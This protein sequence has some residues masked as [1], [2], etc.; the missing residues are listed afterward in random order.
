MG[1]V[2]GLAAAIFALWL[3]LAQN[4][5]QASLIG[6]AAAAVLALA[7]AWRLGALDREG[8]FYFRIIPLAWL[9][10]RRAPAALAGGARVAMGAVGAIETLK[11]GFVRLRIGA[12]SGLARATHTLAA[13][14]AP[15]VAVA[16]SDET[17]VLLHVWSEPAALPAAMLAI[18]REAALAVDGQA[19]AMNA[20][21]A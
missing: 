8:A 11:P 3:A 20:P 7:F 12:A 18:E 21:P 19:A 14:A 2:V 6:G 10:L 17:S 1:H 16:D 5:S 13:S 9:A 15:G 4:T